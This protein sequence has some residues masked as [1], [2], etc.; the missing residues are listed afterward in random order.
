M[1]SKK[2]ITTMTQY[3]T[4]QRSTDSYHNLSAALNADLDKNLINW[5][6][7]LHSSNENRFVL[8]QTPL[9]EKINSDLLSP[10]FY[11]TINTKNSSVCALNHSATIIS[12]NSISDNCMSHNN[13]VTLSGWFDLLIKDEIAARRTESYFQLYQN[14]SYAL[15]DSPETLKDVFIDWVIQ[16]AT[17]DGDVNKKET[18]ELKGQGPLNTQIMRCCIESTECKNHKSVVKHMHNITDLIAAS[19]QIEY[20]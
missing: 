3:N 19:I 6:N 4:S 12:H 2:E 15:T 1:T 10:D 20:G 14:C 16:P 17:I 8:L 5:N 11:K 7:R 9:P 13:S 18:N